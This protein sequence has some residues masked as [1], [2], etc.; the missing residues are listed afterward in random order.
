ME[1]A[2]EGFQVVVT[3]HVTPDG[4]GDPRNLPLKSTYKPGRNVTLVGTAQAPDSASVTA[5]VNRVRGTQQP[6][7]A[8][9]Q[10]GPS[11]AAPAA[12]AAAAPAAPAAIT[13]PNGAKS[14]A[15]IR[16]ELRRAGWGGGSD[17]DA[18]ATYNRLAAAARGN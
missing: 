14:L 10:P 2:R 7:P 1:T 12:P 6:A 15:Q 18:V 11:Q 17:E 9:P 5:A 16:D 3:R 8:A 4:G 13:T